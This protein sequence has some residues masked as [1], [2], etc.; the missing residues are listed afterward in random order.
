MV[1]LGD[2]RTPSVASAVSQD[3]VPPPQRERAEPNPFASFFEQATLDALDDD[4][5]PGG[6]SDHGPTGKTL[7]A[8]PPLNE[9]DFNPFADFLHARED[10][11]V[12]SSTDSFLADSV[13]VPSGLQA[14]FGGRLEG[15]G[16]TTPVPPGTTPSP[17]RSATAVNDGDGPDALPGGRSNTG[18]RPS[19]GADEPAH[20]RADALLLGD[21]DEPPAVKR[22]S[23]PTSADSTA[24]SDN[25]VGGGIAPPS[26]VVDADAPSLTA[27][28]STL[29]D[30]LGKKFSSM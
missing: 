22:S 23:S 10:E 6:L 20:A 27:L 26:I 9:S 13:P 7:D 16:R 1:G 21:V 14:M 28:D 18:R 15:F 30:I 25:A 17:R 2:R 5:P 8:A 24:I 3:D 12:A 29:A 19:D 11:R 4:A